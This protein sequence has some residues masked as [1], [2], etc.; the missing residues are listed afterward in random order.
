MWVLVP[1]KAHFLYN[2]LPIFLVL[3]IQ[4]AM[5][6]FIHSFIHLFLPEDLLAFVSCQPRKLAQSDDL[7]I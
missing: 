3:T 6:S 1:P 5:Y 2:I 4:H 7:V